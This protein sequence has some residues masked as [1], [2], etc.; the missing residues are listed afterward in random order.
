MGVGWGWE[1]LGMQIALIIV[2][3]IENKKESE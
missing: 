3:S 2:K 1:A